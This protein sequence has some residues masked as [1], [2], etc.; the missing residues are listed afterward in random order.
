MDN[1]AWEEVLSRNEELT[2]RRNRTS[3]LNTLEKLFQREQ[4]HKPVTCDI[5]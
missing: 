2:V 1:R 4:R 3:S 5:Y